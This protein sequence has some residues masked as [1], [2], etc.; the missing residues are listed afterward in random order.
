M[1][2]FLLTNGFRSSVLLLVFFCA[3]V[4]GSSVNAFQKECT[5]EA[6]YEITVQQDGLSSVSIATKKGKAPYKYIFCKASGHLVSNDFDSN[7]FQGLKAGKYFAVIIDA[8][9]CRKDLQ[10]EIK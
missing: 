7:E 1:P 9:N 10:I 3:W 2:K 8:N 6:T 5:F 4:G